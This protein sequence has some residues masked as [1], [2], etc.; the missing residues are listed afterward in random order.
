MLKRVAIVDVA[1]TVC[2]QNIDDDIRDISFSLVK[3]LLDRNGL[4][5]EDI[6]TI[7][8]SSSDYWQGISCSNSYYYDA[9][10]G[11]MKTAPKVEEDGALA[12]MYGVM[13]ILSGHFDLAVVHAVTKMSEIPHP[14]VLTNLAADP[15][16]HRAV[17]LDKYSASAL[18]CRLYMDRYKISPEQ[19]AQVVVKNRKN[20]LNNPFAHIRQEVT[21]DQVVSSPGVAG[22]IREMDLP[23]LS[24]GV[25]AILLA[26]EDHA[27]RFATKPCWV[28]GV[29]WSV[30]RS[31]LGDRDLLDGVLPIA[32]RQAYSMAG[33]RDPLMEIDVAEVCERFS[34]E[35]LLWYE[36]LGFCEPGG[37]G[38]LIDNGVTRMGGRLP[39]N[40]SGGVL[41]ANPYC[42][43]GLI[44]VGEAALQVMGAA[45]A[46]QVDG[47]KRALAHSTHG[48][49][50]QMHSV[51]VLEG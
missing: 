40:P 46:R 6:G 36:G 4:K 45:G 14:G 29:G 30:E 41:C 20:A 25:C 32:A 27:G 9:I 18:Q 49:A 48:F 10:G 39:V 12:F 7:T 1:Q 33:I 13:R 28:A 38:R 34:F 43:R 2:Q 16:Y 47:A 37:G 21:L 50:G 35:E 51:V 11:Y 3:D 19:T 42:A 44:R 23:P 22:P 15:F 5:R 24:D 8:T 31:W 17:G 26:S